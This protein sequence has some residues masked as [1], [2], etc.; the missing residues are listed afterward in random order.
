MSAIE[1]AL[2]AGI[3]CGE[4]PTWVPEEQALYFT[5]I[6]D[7]MI[8]RFNPATGDCQSWNMPEEVGCFAMRQK[9]G[10]VAAMRSGFAFIDLETGAVDTIADPEAD[11]PANRF[12]DGRCDR[13]GRFWA[14]TMHEPR[15]EFDGALYR[16]DA[17][18]NC[19]AI[20]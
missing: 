15:T 20:L 11:R 3:I 16:L 7:K 5:D 9:G 10:L 18:R 12:N 4:C 17:D 13:Q 6:P 19:T 1:V 14:G 2:D 8:G